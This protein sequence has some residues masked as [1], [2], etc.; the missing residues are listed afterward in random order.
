MFRVPKEYINRLP[1]SWL[2]VLGFLLVLVVGM[3]DY[4]TG[5]ELSIS[6]FYLIP[7]ALS[8][9]LVGRRT[10]ICLSIFSAAVGLIADLWTGHP[11]SH[12]V[13]LYWNS[14]IQLG[15]YLI[16]VFMLSALTREYAHIA[17]LN[18]DLQDTVSSLNKTQEELERKSQEL[19]RSNAELERFA[20]VAAHDLRQPAI[21]AGAYLERLRRVATVALD[22]NAEQCIRHAADALTRM[23]ALIR[24]LLAYAKVGNSVKNMTL[25]D[26]S[27]IV[28]GALANLQVEIDTYGVAVT[29]D[30]LPT[31]P[32][33]QIQLLQVFQNLIGNS[34]KFRREEPPRIHISA[35]PQAREWVVAI[36]DNG[37]GIAPEH[38]TAIFNIF[39]RVHDGEQYRGN[40]IGLAICKKIV[41]NHGGRIWVEGSPGKGSTFKF[42]MPMR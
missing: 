34:I 17:R 2:A 4:V 20:Y 22:A 42:T 19:T 6:I 8:V 12:P 41:E 25:T 32:A 15:F 14:G 5:A 37:I 3:L 23:E 13:V 24:A 21:V 28:Q 11:F 39:Q 9:V 26:V 10:G 31:V 27:E 30:R 18:D 35:E 33:D 7:I 29:Y 36:A 38:S 16:I 40:G 1:P